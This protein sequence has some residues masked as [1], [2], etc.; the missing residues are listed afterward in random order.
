MVRFLSRSSILV[1]YDDKMKKWN[2]MAK[3][4]SLRYEFS[5]II[6]DICFKHLE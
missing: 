2:V 5:N 3:S 1:K 4:E 6:T